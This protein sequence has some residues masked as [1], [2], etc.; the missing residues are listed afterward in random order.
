MPSRTFDAV[1]DRLDLA[2]GGC[3]FGYGT[4]ALI[5]KRSGTTPAQP[6]S[7]WDGSVGQF[8]IYLTATTGEMHLYTGS[9]SNS[10]IT[11]VSAD[12]WVLIAAGKANGT[13]AGR[14]HKYVYNTGVW[15]HAN[16]DTAIANAPAPGVNGSVHINTV[17]GPNF[18]GMDVAVAAFWS[19]NLTDAELVTL[20][21]S[22][23]AW[24]NQTPQGLW[25]LDQELTTQKVRD[26]TGNG[27]NEIALTGTAVAAGTATI[28]LDFPV[29][30]R[31]N[32][33]R[34]GRGPRRRQRFTPTYLAADVPDVAAGVTP[35]PFIAE[36]ETAWNTTT[37]PKTASVTVAT[38]DILVVIA[39][40]T[41]GS[42]GSQWT[43]PS[44]GGLTYTEQTNASV[45]TASQAGVRIW[46]APCPSG[47]TFTLSVGNSGAAN[48]GFNCLRFGANG[49]V[50]GSDSATSVSGLPS[51]GVTTTGDNSALACANGDWNENAP[52]ATYVTA[53][54]GTAN[55]QTGLLVAGSA[56]FYVWYHANVGSAG[57][58]TIGQSAPAGQAFSVAGVEILGVVSGGLEA[59]I[60]VVTDTG[61]SQAVTGQK[62]SSVG[63]VTET[64]SSRAI[65]ASRSATL[66]RATE[67]D[68]SQALSRAKSKAIGRSVEVDVSRRVGQYVQRV[69]EADISRNLTTAKSKAVSRAVETNTARR[70]G[71]YLGRATETDVSRA[72]AR[73]KTLAV[74][75]TTETN[76][77]RVITASK[78][79]AVTRVSE[80]D[81]ARATARIK[82]VTAGRVAE[83]DTARAF[84]SSKVSA[85]GRATETDI[86]QALTRM[87]SRLVGRATETDTARAMARA[88]ALLLGR[89]VE[90]DTSQQM[91]SNNPQIVRATETDTS[92]A[93]SRSKARSVG[94]AAE[95]DVSR[96]LAGAKYLQISRVAEPDSARALVGAKTRNLLR[97]N[98]INISNAV[99]ARKL[100]SVMRA[101][102]T[103]TARVVTSPA[104]EGYWGVEMGLV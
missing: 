6:I 23:H 74:A 61:V 100:T 87:K 41:F 104:I 22:L 34:P 1:D 53:G 12:G 73:I 52:P 91:P 9:S 13:D 90:V 69:T 75:R 38:G 35:P 98:E 32:N 60:G 88:K 95:S 62:V 7:M 2:I 89:V 84:A 21:N 55:E 8:Q 76:T 59:N 54:L 20:P 39:Q 48:W 25:V 83:T 70:V 17:A 82:A 67:T 50:G 85:V 16:G 29:F 77:A 97:A 19:R 80:T 36:Y 57:V 86:A 28:P 66:G 102:E 10:T 4:F 40:S 96:T 58:K 5:A 68:T 71:Q 78:T 37:T 47:Q 49:G 18:T 64:D 46:T 26:L 42:P 27:A 103:D 31:P 30:S 56:A 101:A 65:S 79:L 51:V 72:I 94:R 3:N 14:F 63:R 11:F 93:V 45:S 44:G 24:M 81:S 92:R 99:S 15:T 33:D 43:A